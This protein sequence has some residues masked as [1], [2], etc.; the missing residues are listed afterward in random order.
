MTHEQIVAAIRAG[1]R[2]VPNDTIVQSIMGSCFQE[3]E[4][5]LAELKY[6]CLG[7]NWY[8]YRHGT[9]IGVEHDGYIHS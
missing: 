8:F 4:K 2:P 3:P 1:Q 7:R 9:Y 6:D 5:I